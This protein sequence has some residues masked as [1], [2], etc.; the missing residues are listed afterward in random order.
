MSHIQQMWVLSLFCYFGKKLSFNIENRP[1]SKTI[2]KN[3]WSWTLPWC[4]YLITMCGMELFSMFLY[5]KHEHTR[6]VS[7]SSLI[8]F[9]LQEWI[10]DI[11]EY[12]TMSAS[13]KG[14]LKFLERKPVKDKIYR[15]SEDIVNGSIHVVSVSTQ[16]T[17]SLIQH[18]I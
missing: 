13:N 15:P 4:T 6:L 12:P 8:A 2:F 7:V 5:D 11:A 16:S 10:I 3:L 18:F 1:S 14:E 17:G 9:Y